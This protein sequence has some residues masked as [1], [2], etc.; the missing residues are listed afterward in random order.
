MN[1]KRKVFTED[2]KKEI[3]KL[4]TE[5]GKKSIDVARNIDVTPT[6]IRR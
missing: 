4:V 3:V 5:L 2:Y 6:T 1:N